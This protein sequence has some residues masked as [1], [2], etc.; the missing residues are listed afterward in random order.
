MTEDQP[1]H[2]EHYGALLPHNAALPIGPSVYY[3]VNVYMDT[4]QHHKKKAFLLVGAMISPLFPL[5][6][7]SDCILKILC[8]DEIIL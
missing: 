3:S 5:Q 2:E 4:E 8:N 6:Y 7:H 1:V